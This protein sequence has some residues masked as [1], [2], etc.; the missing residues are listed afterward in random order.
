MTHVI[1]T[2][3]L[4]AEG[5]LNQAQAEEII[6]RSRE[7]M[8]GLVVNL[9]LTGGI[10]AAALGFVFWIADPA[11]VAILGLIFL[12]IGTAVLLRNSELYR[13]LGNAAALIGAGMLFAGATIELADKYDGIV[14]WVL[15]PIGAIAAACAAWAYPRVSAHLR[16][17]AG[18]VGLMGLA[19][20]LAGGL[21]ALEYFSVSGLPVSLFSLYAAVVIGLAGWFVDVRFVTALAIVPFAQAL[22]TS[23]DYFH[24]AYVFYSPESTLTIIQMALIIGA[25]AWVSRNFIDRHSRHAGVLAIMAAVVG[26][27]AFLVGTL[28]GDHVGM[29]FFRDGRPVWSDFEDWTQLNAAREVWEAQFFYISEEIY[30]V[31]FAIVLVAGAWWS[32]VKV[33]RGL[34]NTAVTFLGIHAYTQ[35]FESFSDEPMAYALGGLA[36]I[37]LAW[38]IWRLNQ[39]MFRA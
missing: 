18:S 9:L 4:L 7:T 17:A 14:H 15:L 30:S 20:H 28:W 25:S 1:Q 23:V 2:E 39:K 38:G 10:I 6:R 32:A 13:M 29:S 22:N 11:G 16:F 21:F 37:P 31:A 8:L 34:F 27:L 12:V 35:L 33:R 3:Q 24:A 26:A 36:A 19:V 5:I